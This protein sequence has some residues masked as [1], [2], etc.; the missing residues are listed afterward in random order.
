MKRGSYR[1]AVKGKCPE[2]ERLDMLRCKDSFQ[3]CVP[4]PA[5]DRVKV[6]EVADGDTITVDKGG[7]RVRIRFYGVDAPEMGQ[8]YGEKAREF[9]AGMIEGQE[10]RLV[11]RD[12][13]SLGMMVAEVYIGESSLSSALVR[14]GLAWWYKQY[15]PKDKNLA[16]LEQEARAAKLGL[17]ADQNSIPPWEWKEKAKLKD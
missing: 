9:V 13:T 1:E 8:P 15:A 17:W 14:A 10:V 7:E 4:A 5:A 3:W 6:I 16:Q 2:G 12:E 11:P